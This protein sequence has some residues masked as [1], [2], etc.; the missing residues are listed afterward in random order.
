MQ[1]S[2]IA[3]AEFLKVVKTRSFVGFLQEPWV[4]RGRLAGLTGI[5]KHHSQEAHFRAAICHSRDINVW[6]VPQFTSPDVTTCIWRPDSSQTSK[7][8][9]LISAY[10]SGNAV[11]I[12]KEL[13]EAVEFCQR[14]N[15]EFIC[16]IDSNAH[17]SWWGSPRTDQR[18]EKLEDFLLEH[19]LFLLNQGQTNTFK[20][21]VGQ[22]KIDITFCSAFI[23]RNI[24]NWKVWTN[25]SGSDHRIINMKFEPDS[26]T[27]KWT[28]NLK[29]CNWSIFGCSLQNDWCEEPVSWSSK[30]IEKE[31]KH[32]Y[33][34][35]E[36]A[37]RDSCTSVRVSSNIKMKWWTAELEESRKRVRAAWHAACKTPSNENKE[38]CRELRQE[39]KRLIAREKRKH[40]KKFSSDVKSS[41]ET[42]SLYKIIQRGQNQR[43]LGMVRKPNG[44]MTAS[45]SEM[46]NTLLDQHFPGSTTDIPE[47]IAPT[48]VVVAPSFDWINPKRFRKAVEGFKNDKAAGPDEIKPI[49][50]KNLPENVIIR[51]CNIF[52]A[53]IAVGYTP[54]AWRHSKTIFIGKEGRA[55]Y[56]DPKAFRPISLMSFVFKTLERLVLWHSEES[57]LKHFPLHR[58]QHAFRRGHSAEVSLSK[59][60]SFIEET[61]E[62]KELA[63][64][65]FLDIEGAY[66]NTS[67]KAVIAGM[68]KHGF[69]I[70][71]INWYEFYLKNR[72]CEMDAG[73]AK[74]KR[75]LKT[76]VP[77]G[78]VLSVV[79]FNLA[80]DDF[81]VECDLD[82]TDVI[83]FADDGCIMVRGS[84]LRT[85]LTRIQHTL[86]RVSSWAERVG[87]KF[88]SSK[89]CAV[90]FT[91]KRKTLIDNPVL[92]L[93][94]Q[95]IPFK[96]SVRYLGVILDKSLTFREH[97]ETKLKAAKFKTHLVRNAIGKFWGPCPAQM[98]WIY[99]SIIR[100][101]IT[102]GCLVWGRATKHKYFLQKA[103]K[104]QRSALM[105]MAPVRTH[106]PTIAME[107]IAF[108]PPLDLFIESEVVLAFKRVKNLIDTSITETS[109]NSLTSHLVLAVKLEE[110]SGTKDIPSEVIP[111]QVS[112]KQ[113]WKTVLEPFDPILNGEPNMIG[114]YTDGSKIG[115]LAGAGVVI[116]LD[117]EIGRQIP[118]KTFSEHLGSMSSVFQAEVYAIIM[119]I[120]EL[121]AELQDPSS[122]VRR[123]G[124]VKVISDSRSA[125]LAINSPIVKSSL[126]SECILRLHRLSQSRLVTLHWI[127]AHQGHAGNELA[128]T[129]AKVGAQWIRPGVEPIL[130]VAKTW[131]KRSLKRFVCEK[132]K[133]RWRSV[134]KARQTKIFFDGPQEQKSKE[135]LRWNREKYGEFFRW[136]T[137]HNFLKRHNHLLNPEIFPDPTC[138]ACGEDEETSSHLLLDCPVLGESR[139]KILG[140]HLF[141]ELHEWVPHQ[142]FQ[143]IEVAKTYCEELSEDT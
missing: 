113:S 38:K 108:V 34:R 115:G 12:P 99:T 106:S 48:K 118:Y 4:H 60:V 8:I 45:V 71:I 102:Y 30:E 101:S 126:V 96:T 23:H 91:R 55:S 44:M 39:H 17:S 98:R 128:D 54:E 92:K 58:N 76:G 18:G 57:A 125:L 139:F 63:V 49:I 21:P 107:V 64:V 22:S 138:R 111:P 142:L 24:K 74:Y 97:V 5:Q 3:S 68:V 41:K 7:E 16:G 132:W 127:R 123:S 61:Y 81:L 83:G 65:V 31:V 121:E 136:I 124:E 10:W 86:D 85:I 82:G 129:K 119:A 88:S 112:W 130:P 36:K 2:K 35:V 6:E 105:P 103:E 14:K 87:L 116:T 50:L 59:M 77:Q 70:E 67:T 47:S 37:L 120:T 93:N 122:P 66:D 32:F 27:R 62:R 140:Q 33:S 84:D 40:W 29:T 25:F 13:K 1:H 72:T 135:I 79:A 20:T 73:G 69:P 51:L 117:D 28:R 15:I 95:E 134:A 141:R 75:H 26:E 78:G 109:R 137:G 42:S 94:N 11:E 100:P 9:Y 114:A 53:C 131:I 19:N 110:E 56:T 52:A 46:A 133:D 89:S 43:N 90:I 143:M 80:M 104:L